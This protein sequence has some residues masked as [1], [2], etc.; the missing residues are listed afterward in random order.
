MASSGLVLLSPRSASR[1]RSR[2]PGWA[3]GAGRLAQPERGGEQ[4]CVGL[5]V[6]A[7]HED[8]ARLE[9]RVV[10]HQPDEH[11]AQHL[12]LSGRA[13][14]GVHLHRA[15]RRARASRPDRAAC[16]RRAGRPAASDSSGVAAL[17]VPV[18]DVLVVRARGS[19]ATA[20][21]PGSRARARR[22]TG[23]RRS[24]PDASSR[25]RTGP[26]ATTSAQLGPGGRRACGS[27]RCTSRTSPTA[28][29]QLELGDRQPGVPEHR[30][31]V[32]Q[33]ERLAVTDRLRAS[34]CAGRP[35]AAAS[36][37]SSSA[38]QRCGCQARSSGRS[39]PG[40]V[41]VPPRA[42][43]GEQPSVAARRTTRR[44]RRGG[45]RPTS[46]GRGAARPVLGVVALTE[47]PGEGRAPAAR[48]ATRRSPRAAA[49]PSGR[50]PRGRRPRCR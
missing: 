37:R 31:P 26:A 16:G 4:R 38:R 30:Q 20:A 28:A 35:A 45:A 15:V 36:T 19:S 43:V 22:A 23:A 21:A 46:G 34:R 11:L 5:D 47:V 7:H 2:W 29:Q 39:A 32:G 44:G 33:R 42:P 25:R 1:T 50:G 40:P 17:V 41:G 24:R 10:L 9:R 3:S 49:R 12:D 48:R 14:A 18:D 8:V 13:V 6:G 27:Q